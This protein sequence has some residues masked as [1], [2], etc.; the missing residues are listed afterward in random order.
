MDD[1]VIIAETIGELLKRFC[2]WKSNLETK[3]LHLNAGKTMIT[4]SAH[5]ARKPVETS[6]FSSGK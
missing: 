2:V 1:L 6:K 4:T 5:N 3:G